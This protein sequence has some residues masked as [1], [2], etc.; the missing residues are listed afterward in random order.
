[1]MKKISFKPAAGAA[2]KADL[3]DCHDDTGQKPQRNGKFN[4]W[5]Y[6]LCLLPLL[7]FST[8]S[9]FKEPEESGPTGLYLGVIGFN[10]ELNVKEITM[11]NETSRNSFHTFI[12]SFRM[13]NG[14]I[15]YYAVESAIK[16]LKKATLPKD[17]VNVSIIT[18]TDGLDQGSLGMNS[19]HK[20]KSSYL[21][22]LKKQ[23]NN[24]KIRGKEISAYSIGLKG[25]DV[26]DDRE[27]SDNLR[28]LSSSPGNFY[29]ART[30]NEVNDRFGEIASSLYNETQMQYLK[31]TIPVQEDKAVI[32]FTFDNI[33]DAANSTFYIEG[34]FNLS[35]K[36]LRNITYNGFAEQGETMVKG[37]IEG[38]FV[39]FT[40]VNLKPVSTTVMPLNYVKQWELKTSLWQ[41]NSEFVP[42]RNS[43]LIQEWKS[44]VILLV[45]DCSTSLGSDFSSLQNSARDFI[46]VLLNKTVP[47][48]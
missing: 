48:R 42:G 29:E 18:F 38:I 45:L 36:S 22:D 39:T 19:K 35:D 24:T 47:Q 17:L 15:L 33:S 14:T 10:E 6:L 4:R 5:V 12:N 2:M 21:E 26:S 3:K 8:C 1:M 43:D 11:L 31:L 13:L 46:D 44:A 37:E 30:M 40:F 7:L 32:R 28:N 27:F 16:E 41:I 34:A 20:T 9:W 23:I 25:D